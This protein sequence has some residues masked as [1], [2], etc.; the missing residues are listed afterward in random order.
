VNR[1][2]ETPQDPAT[3]LRLLSTLRCFQ[4]PRIQFLQPLELIH[5]LLQR[6]A[7]YG[8]HSYRAVLG[9]PVKLNASSEGSRTAFR[10]E[11]GAGKRAAAL[12]PASAQRDSEC[13][14]RSEAQSDCNDQIYA[15]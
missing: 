8:P 6:Q 10:D 13:D 4:D 1:D 11:R 12:V 14:E 3:L 2:S 9:I 7:I 5:P 15:V